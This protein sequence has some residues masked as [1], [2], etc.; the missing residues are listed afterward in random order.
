M[1]LYDDDVQGDKED[2]SIRDHTGEQ[3]ESEQQLKG[4]LAQIPADLRSKLTQED[5]ASL[6]LAAD[7][8]DF[9]AA[10]ESIRERELQEV[11]KKNKFDKILEAFFADKSEQEK[12][13]IASIFQSLR[14]S[15]VSLGVAANNQVAPTE[16]P[17]TKEAKQQ[18][19]QEDQKWSAPR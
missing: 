7:L 17:V 16:S 10:L 14:S 3:L 6:E 8:D 15:M 12:R 4:F 2:D 19:A 11:A 18:K 9:I 5:L 13:V 1:S